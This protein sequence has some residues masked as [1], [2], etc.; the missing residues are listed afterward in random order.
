VKAGDTFLLADPGIDPHLW[1][2]LSDP[3]LDPQNVVIA[4]FTTWESYKD[5]SCI[6]NRGDHPWIIH[7]SCVYFRGTQIVSNELLD[8]QVLAGALVPQ[9][10]LEKELLDRIRAASALSKEMKGRPYSILDDQGLVPLF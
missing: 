6:V 9:A 4:S 7:K 1:F 2:V 3:L 10:P 8:K 5:Q